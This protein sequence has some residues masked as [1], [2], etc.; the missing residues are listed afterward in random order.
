M[1]AGATDGIYVTAPGIP[2]YGVSGMFVDPDLGNIRGLN[3]R[4]GVKSLLDGR[5]FQYRLIKR[6]AEQ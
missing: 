3:E 2:T 6:Y 5:R 4:I 1:T